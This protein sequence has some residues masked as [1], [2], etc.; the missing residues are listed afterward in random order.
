MEALPCGQGDP[1]RLRF[2]H[3]LSLKKFAPGFRRV[4]IRTWDFDRTGCGINR[5]GGPARPF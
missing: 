1:G 4:M 2:L 3:I 5:G